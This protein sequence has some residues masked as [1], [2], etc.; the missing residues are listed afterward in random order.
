MKAR[1]LLTNNAGRCSWG[2][3]GGWRGG[4]DV[5]SGS[6]VFLT[7]QVKNTMWMI[8]GSVRVAVNPAASCIIQSPRYP[9]SARTEWFCPGS[10]RGKD[11]RVN[12]LLP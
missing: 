10:S 3:E 7:S 6:N 8:N 9:Q 11:L 5:S 12:P 1:W 2:G 4:G